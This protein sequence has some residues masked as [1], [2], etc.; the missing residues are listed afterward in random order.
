MDI[1]KIEQL[2]ENFYSEKE[3]ASLG[4]IIS[5][6][7]ERLNAYMPYFEDKLSKQKL[8]EELSERIIK[9]P[10]IKITERWGE[11]NNEDRE[12]F[13]TLMNNVKGN[14]V[15]AKLESVSQFLNHI[16]GLSIPEILSNLMFVEIFSNI[17][18][19]FNPSTAGFLFEAFLAGLFQ[20][21]QIAD[22]EGGSLPIEDVEL[23]VARGFGEATEVEEVVPYSLKVLSPNTD[24]KGS[25]VN[26]VDFFRKKKENG[27]PLHQGVIY[28]AVTKLGGTGPVG[29]LQFF[30]FQIDRN[31]FF[32]WIG[33][34]TIERKRVYE[35][36]SFVPRE[37]AKVENNR[38]Y[39][40]K[41]VIGASPIR[42]KKTDDGFV[43]AP[44]SKSRKS[45][46][47]SYDEIPAEEEL[48][49][50][51]PAAVTREPF[52]LS[53]ESGP[54]ETGDM[55]DMD[56]E[57]FIV[58]YT[59]EDEFVKTG[60]RAA[61]HK[62]LYGDKTYDI[63]PDIF[64]DLV[65]SKGYKT[66]QQWKIAPRFY[67]EMGTM[68]GELDLSKERLKDVFRAYASNLGENLI[69]LYNALSDLSI[70]INKYFLAS[71]KS[72]GLTAIQNAKDIKREADRIIE[73]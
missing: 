67:R 13:E 17:L 62:K 69:T 64:D 48:Y 24:L 44:T 71:D 65:D 54:L 16:D 49:F 37:Q 4:S 36:I 41:T 61:V 3:T 56:Q 18:E 14:S 30:E 38:L 26:L 39:L 72:A 32:D 55:I 29:K 52:K 21:V 59:G 8:M 47:L 2:V 42:G 34:E 46:R 15:A 73:K 43:K 23:F 66:N 33:H 10:K 68:I 63:G 9:F 58:M 51:A 6:I 40:G 31:N 5:L 57:H 7:E 19:E 27:E 50:R 28:L 22:P 35:E 20:G 53:T 1:N 25:F 60:E 11:K 12:I 45:D 70:N